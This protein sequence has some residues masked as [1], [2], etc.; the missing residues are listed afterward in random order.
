VRAE[1]RFMNI[2]LGASNLKGSSDSALVPV[3]GVGAGYAF[4]IPGTERLVASLEAHV[5]VS[6][7]VVQV[8]DSGDNVL[9]QTGY[10]FW[11]LELTTAIALP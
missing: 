6:T 10:V 5:D 1:G 9:V 3:A 2:R 8:V 7:F 4:R 11:G